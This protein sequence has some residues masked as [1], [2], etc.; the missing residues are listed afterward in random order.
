MVLKRQ[1]IY[2]YNMVLPVSDEFN[3]ILRT[4]AI[5]KDFAIAKKNC[6]VNRKETKIINGFRL[7]NI[8]STQIKT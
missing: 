2:L 7:L 6:C 5:L 1:Q 4:V 8:T 3:G